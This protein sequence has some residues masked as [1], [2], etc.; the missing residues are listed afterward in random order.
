MFGKKKLMARIAELEDRITKL[1]NM[2]ARVVPVHS[3]HSLFGYDSE[4]TY[5]N[6][7]ATYCGRRLTASEIEGICE[8]PQIKVRGAWTKNVPGVTHEELARYV[9]D[10]TPIKRAKEK[11]V[12][13]VTTYSPGE[14]TQSVKTDIGDIS[15]TEGI[16]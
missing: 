12:T 2:H 15:I 5:D 7:Q 6:K 4:Y 14:K 10:G 9:L 3:W 16:D 11:A 1:E 13:Y 8:H